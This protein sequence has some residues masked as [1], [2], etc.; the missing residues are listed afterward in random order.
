MKKLSFL[1]G[2]FALVAA[3]RPAH[4]LL[5][6]PTGYICE[7][8]WDPT[9]ANFGSSGYIFLNFY[10]GPSCT[11]SFLGATYVCSTGAPS[12]TCDLNTLYSVTQMSAL[13][14]NLSRAQVSNQRVD[15]VIAGG[16]SSGLSNIY[17]YAAGY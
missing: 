5:N 2:L 13:F 3:P 4:A 7:M 1:I 8:G 14:Q 9:Y 16:A 15:F 17:F 10:S 12:A 11:G 6:Y